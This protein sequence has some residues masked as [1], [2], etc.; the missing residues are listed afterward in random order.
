MNNLNTNSDKFKKIFLE[1]IMEI[2]ATD[3]SGNKNELLFF[4]LTKADNLKNDFEQYQYDYSKY[5][6]GVFLWF[7][8]E[9]T[10]LLEFLNLFIKIPYRIL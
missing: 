4:L 6:T 3:E 7:Q 8:E 9:Y 5:N 1:E 2:L 10:N